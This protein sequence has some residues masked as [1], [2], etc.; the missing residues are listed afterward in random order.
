MGSRTV[1][2]TRD[3]R[4]VAEQVIAR[5]KDEQGW[6]DAFSAHLDRHRAGRSLARILSV[7]NLSQAETAR[8]LGISRQAVGK[9]LERG[10]PIDRAEMVGDL[11][12][13]TDI[14]VHYLQVDRIPVVVRR[15]IPARDGKSVLDL[16]EHGDSRDVLATCR[17]MF[18]LGRV[19]S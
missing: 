16:L 10:A 1:P 15:P 7:W 6:L 17:E 19:H 18:D 12:A 4:A 9:W 2:E 13:A 5:Y 11:A 14:L 3:P 8:L